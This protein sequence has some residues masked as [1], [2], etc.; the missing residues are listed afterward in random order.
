[1]MDKEKRERLDRLRAKLE[2]APLMVQVEFVIIASV[3]SAMNNP[4]VPDETQRDIFSA[5]LK[6]HRSITILETM[7]AVANL[8]EHSGDD[9][10]AFCG[11]MAEMH[12]RSEDAFEMFSSRFEVLLELLPERKS[13]H[14]HH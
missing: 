6:Y 1:M 5:A 10:S 9:Q 7:K 14:D 12:E 4:A 2:D 13:K 11:A 8:H 3:L